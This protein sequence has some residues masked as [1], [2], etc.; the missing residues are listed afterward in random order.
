MLHETQQRESASWQEQLDDAPDVH[1][2]IGIA[3][4]FLATWDRHE[5]AALP[6]PC[7]PGKVFDANDIQSYAF[8]LMQ[9][10]CAANADAAP[11]IDKMAAFFSN[12]SIRLSQILA[13]QGKANE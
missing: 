8:Q 12:A 4:N 6:E 7:R 1:D 5:L 9:H 13:S 2:V 10:D 11:L 3:R